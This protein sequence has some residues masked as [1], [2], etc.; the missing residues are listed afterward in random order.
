[1]GVLRV[2]VVDSGAGIAP[3]NH[4]RVFGQFA[5]FHSNELQGGGGSGL[6]LWI[7]KRIVNMHKGKMGFFSLG[8]GFGSTF[9]FEL[10]VFSAEAAGQVFTPQPLRRRS[11]L[12]LPK[13][14]RSTAGTTWT[15]RDFDGNTLPQLEPD[16]TKTEHLYSQFSHVEQGSHLFLG[17]TSASTNC[18]Q[19]RRNSISNV[20]CFHSSGRS[21]MI[22]S[23]EWSHLRLDGFLHPHGAHLSLTHF[24]PIRLCDG[25]RTRSQQGVPRTGS[26]H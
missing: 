13:R 15:T 11:A 18:F 8:E 20:E 9:F 12:F 5:Q 21:S 7:S 4:K 1:M 3:E 14:R 17:T 2:E 16:A 10:P 25:R 23:K 22:P 19:K 26:I 6:G 24:F